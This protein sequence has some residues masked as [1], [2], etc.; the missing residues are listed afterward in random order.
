MK[1]T[2]TLLALALI[3]MSS[4]AQR[5]VDLATTDIVSPTELN[6]VTVGQ[7]L[8]TAWAID[9]VVTN[10]GTDSIFAGD[11]LLWGALITDTISKN[12]LV[13]LPSTFGQGQRLIYIPTRDVPP[14]DTLHFTSNWTINRGVSVSRDMWMTFVVQTFDSEIEAETQAT[15]TDNVRQELLVWYDVK[16]WGVSVE[17]VVYNNNLDVYPNPASTVLNV[18]ILHSSFSNVSIELYDLSGKLV[19]SENNLERFDNNYYNLDVSAVDNG[20]Y[21]LRVKHGD[22]VSTTKVSVSH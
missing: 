22:D 10:Q 15:F 9:V 1:K 6:S 14:G 20:M 2:F 8:R 21:I 17:E 11:T 18:S 3:T 7:D 4:Y 5:S 12:T 16:G 13:A 19:L